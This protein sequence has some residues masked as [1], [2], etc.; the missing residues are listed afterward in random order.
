MAPTSAPSDHRKGPRRYRRGW[1]ATKSGDGSPMTGL[2]SRIVNLAVVDLKRDPSRHGILE[3]GI[4]GGGYAN[5]GAT[6]R[7]TRR[8]GHRMN[9]AIPSNRRRGR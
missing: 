5:E 4:Q 7:R 3:V 9:A 2:R 1:N 6:G 8:N